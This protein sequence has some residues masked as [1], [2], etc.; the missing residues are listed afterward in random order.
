MTKKPATATYEK[1]CYKCDTL[2]KVGQPITW[3]RTGDHKGIWFH[4][5]CLDPD[6]AKADRNADV[7]SPDTSPDDWGSDD[8]NGGNDR[9]PNPEPNQGYKKEDKDWVGEIIEKE[10]EIKEQ[11]RQESIKKQQQ[12]TEQFRTEIARNTELQQ[13]L[14]TQEEAHRKEE[15]ELNK[16]LSRLERTVKSMKG[17]PDTSDDS[18]THCLVPALLELLKEGDVYLY[19]LPGNGKTEATVQVADILALDYSSISL[20][21]TSP[22]WKLVGF[23]L[24]HP[25]PEGQIQYYEP[26]FAHWFEH[27]GLHCIDEIDNASGALLTSIDTALSQ[28]FYTFPKGMVKRH[29]NARLVVT[30]NTTGLGGDIRFPDRQVLDGAFRNRFQFLDWT[31]DEP[32]ELAIIMSIDKDMGLH[33]LEWVRT[34]RDY[35]SAN[36]P[37]HIVGPRTSIQGAKLMT[38]TLSLDLIV[39]ATMWKGLDKDNVQMIIEACPYN[40]K[41]KEMA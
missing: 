18:L 7:P 30:G 33:W 38:S 28:G 10:A 26:S 4:V 17:L 12:D 3:A 37:E 19:G 40:E 24:P 41:L 36:I 29:E 21:P 14:E 2:I 9:P 15:H 23:P 1:Q 5:D 20:T 8:D 35:C 6:G 32:L 34:V 27:G 13:K 31:L 22:D 11:A 16:R 39:N 25:D